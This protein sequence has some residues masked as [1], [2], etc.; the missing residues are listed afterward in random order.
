M[1]EKKKVELGAWGRNVATVLPPKKKH[2]NTA[3]WVGPV[4]IGIGMA[5]CFFGQTKDI[6]PLLLG[7]GIG[8]FAV[9]CWD[10]K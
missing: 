3:I 10:W 6:A 9:G 8:V 1:A 5:G 2:S 7:F 4:L